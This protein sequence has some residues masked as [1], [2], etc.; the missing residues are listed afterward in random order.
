MK[1]TY[2]RINVKAYDGTEAGPHD[3]IPRSTGEL[4]ITPKAPVQPGSTI[5]WW[6]HQ[7]E[8]QLLVPMYPYMVPCDPELAFGFMLQLGV[9]AGE[10][11]QKLTGNLL[12]LHLSIGHPV[13]EVLQGQQPLWQYQVGLAL[14]VK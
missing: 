5:E 14:R 12:H 2:N 8:D 6:W 1:L 7:R 10:Q 4:W 9:T 3:I 13:N 11:A